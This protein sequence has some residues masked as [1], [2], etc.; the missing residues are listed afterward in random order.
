M[1]KDLKN[2]KKY[3]EVL[4]IG[5]DSTF[6]E[7]TSAY[8]FLK[9]LYSKDKNQALVE[10]MED[11]SE[12]RREEVLEEIEKSYTKLKE[13]FL[14]N[15]EDEKKIA[16]VIPEDIEF[17]GSLLRKIRKEMVIAIKEVSADTNIRKTYLRAIEQED[18][19]SLPPAVYTRG[20]VKAYAEFLGLP[21]EKVV[22]DF[23]KKFESKSP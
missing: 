22:K 10:A 6:T 16:P 15:K 23:M 11:F 9:K 19:G 4:E 20:F 18:Y 2:I 5:E 17:S 13:Y 12:N 7:V 3:F 21:Y 8:R 14:I 1:V